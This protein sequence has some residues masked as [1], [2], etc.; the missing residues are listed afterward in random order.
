MHV[1][2]LS[3]PYVAYSYCRYPCLN[4]CVSKSRKESDGKNMHLMHIY[5]YFQK[6]LCSHILLWGDGKIGKLW[7]LQL[8]KWYLWLPWE[9]IIIWQCQ[10]AVRVRRLDRILKL[11]YGISRM[12]AEF[13]RKIKLWICRNECIKYVT[14]CVF[15]ITLR[16]Y[17]GYVFYLCVLTMYGSYQSD[18]EMFCVEY[19]WGE[20]D[21]TRM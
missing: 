11:I 20:L 12:Q 5:R 16:D 2:H 14:N 6:V 8:A 21:N 3:E 15:W 19:N 18:D 7:Y 1:L 13:K 10:R 9:G 4:Q 17:V